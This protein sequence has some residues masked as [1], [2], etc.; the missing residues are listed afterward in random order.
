MSTF[1]GL[2]V[3]HVDQE[4]HLHMDNYV[5]EILRE[6]KE[7]ARK[8]LRPKKLP[9]APNHQ[10]PRMPP[11]QAHEREP[12][13]TSFFRSF[14]M[15][16]QYAATWVRF[17]ISFTVSQLA[18]HT[19]SPGQP[20]WSALH[21]LMEYLEQYPSLRL[22][23]RRGSRTGKELSPLGICGFGLGNGDRDAQVHIRTGCPIW[24]DTHLMEVQE[25]ADHRSLIG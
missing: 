12:P 9:I 20:H 19:S 13:T 3:D 22:E 5:E 7:Y 2:Q 11:L 10:L 14:V 24:H 17:D 15:K 16:L 6:Y 21:H 25:A 8:T 23:Y 1:F 4:I 18:N